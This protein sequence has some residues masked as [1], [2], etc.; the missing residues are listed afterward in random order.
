MFYKG[1]KL[2]K[3]TK[4]GKETAS[5]VTNVESF[6]LILCRLGFKEAGRVEKERRLY[7][8]EGEEVSLDQ[9]KGLGSF[10]EIEEMSDNLEE[11][12]AEVLHVMKE[13]GLEKSERR[14]YLE[15]IIEKEKS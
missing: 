1:P 8:Y 2:D 6:Q 5:P 14:S 9:V 13:L 15:L 4:T 12:R 3:V 11:G 10:V 7:S